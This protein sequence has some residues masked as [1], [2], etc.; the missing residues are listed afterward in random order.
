MKK[1]KT[2]WL[3]VGFS[4]LVALVII[5]WQ[6]VADQPAITYFPDNHA[7]IFKSYGTRLDLEPTTDKL[8]WTTYSTLLR[9]VYLLQNFSLLYHNNRLT[10]VSNVWKNGAIH[11]TAQKIINADSGYFQAITVHQAEMHQHEAIYGK[12]VASSAQ[13]FV[14]ANQ[15]GFHAF[16]TPATDDEKRF[17]AAMLYHLNHQQRA[18]LERAARQYT[19]QLPRYKLLTLADLA[20]TPA[21]DVFSSDPQ[22]AE[23]I[24][25]QLWEGLYKAVVNGFQMGENQ[26]EPA[27]GSTLPLL[28]IG[29]DH[30]LIVTEAASDHIIVLKQ[31]L[32]TRR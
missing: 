8:N 23:R 24:S 13:L 4:V 21:E 10:E 29:N 20:D 22:G 11:L 12:E 3:V 16:S 28:L 6:T 32:S 15:N 26:Y 19:I 1:N 2:P 7:P 30:V 17:A 5:R 25:G 31:Q 14:H 9:P 18:L 27:I